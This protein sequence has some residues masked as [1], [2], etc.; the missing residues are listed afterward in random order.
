MFRVSY[1]KN[2]VKSFEISKDKRTVII[3]LNKLKYSIRR[4]VKRIKVYQS[5]IVIIIQHFNETCSNSNRELT[6]VQE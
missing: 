4:Y 5:A 6:D 2:I 3:K 1:I